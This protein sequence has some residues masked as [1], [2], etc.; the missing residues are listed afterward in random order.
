MYSGEMRSQEASGAA[1]SS[2]APRGSTRRA[3]WPSQLRNQLPSQLPSQLHGSLLSQLQLAQAARCA[4]S[5]AGSLQREALARTREGRRVLEENL[6]A[7][8]PDLSAIS[9]PPSFR[10]N[11]FRGRREVCC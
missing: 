4:G 6:A 3:H 2:S 8:P 1:A 11:Q 9:S 7:L 10:F 5:C